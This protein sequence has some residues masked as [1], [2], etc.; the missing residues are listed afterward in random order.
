MESPQVTV[1]APHFA[2][3]SGLA[4]PPHFL[5]H[6][7]HGLRRVV[8]L[9]DYSPGKGKLP[10]GTVAVYEKSGHEFDPEFL[11]PDIGCGMLLASFDKPL[12][13]LEHVAYK[14]CTNQN[15]Q[16]GGGQSFY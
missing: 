10:V 14:V 15:S 8:V 16:I 3:P 2:I 6:D 1:L 5:P 7:R 12:E 9:P 4:L 11:G 13:D